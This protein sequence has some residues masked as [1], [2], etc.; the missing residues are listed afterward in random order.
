LIQIC[1]AGFDF[2]FPDKI[3]RTIANFRLSQAGVTKVLLAVS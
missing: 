3:D 1:L 2:V